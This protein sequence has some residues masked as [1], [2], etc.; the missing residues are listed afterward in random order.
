MRRK[1][2]DLHGPLHIVVIA[3]CHFS[4]SAARAIHADSELRDVFARHATWLAAPAQPLADVADWNREFPD[5][6]MQVA[7]T[8]GEWSML[9]DW[10]MPT[11]YVFRDGHE[12]AQFQGWSGVETLKRELRRA[13]VLT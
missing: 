9:D 3:G 6:P 10:A 8:T 7:W 4:E 2:I 5:M 11:Y 12:T 13:K 1:V